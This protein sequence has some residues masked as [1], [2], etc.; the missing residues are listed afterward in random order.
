MTVSNKHFSITPARE[1]EW[2]MVRD[3][4]GGEGD[5]K[6]ADTKYLPRPNG[7]ANDEGGNAMWSGYK[8]R[9]QFPE[10]FGPTINALMGIAHAR[11]TK[12]ELPDALAY[13]EEDADGEGTPLEELHRQ[14]TRE[15]ITSGRYGLLAD[16]P[17]GSADPVL[18]GYR[19][20]TII[21][22]DTDFA[23]LDESGKERNGFDWKDVVRHKVL[24][25]ED[26]QYTVTD[27]LDNQPQDEPVTPSALGGKGIDVIPLA[28][29]NSVKLTFDLAPPPLIGVARAAIAIYQLSADYR[30]QLYNTG[31]ETLVAVNGSAPTNV[32]PGV[33]HEMYGSEGVTPDLKYVGPSCSGIDANKE[34]IADNR[35]AAVM[36]GAKLLE[37]SE[38]VQESGD[39]RQL[40]F[41]SETATLKT[42]VMASC[43]L[44]EKVLRYAAMFKG[45]D[46]QT[47]IVTPPDE[48]LSATITPQDAATLFQLVVDGG[49]SWEDYH[50][51]LQRGG[52]ISAER[53]ADETYRQ[54]QADGMDE[55]PVD[56]STQTAMPQP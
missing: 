20:E 39:A 31:V 15:L 45:L 38:S 35:T 2:A 42:V 6:A 26:G 4:I 11:E 22:W 34:A 47:V 12:I 13:L 37:Q 44:L 50:A 29:A 53:D 41:Q 9:A 21:N 24:S 32:G 8:M 5:V 23:V 17:D 10:M 30:W 27:Y 40:R 43:A 16:V 51:N 48:L 25:V 54:I 7:F 33:V 19:A 3:C 28:V 1:A 56:T 18:I 14:I 36:A 46:P 52:L 55:E 49:L